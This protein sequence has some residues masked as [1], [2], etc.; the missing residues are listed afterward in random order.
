M[1]TIINGI[2]ILINS[3]N[4]LHN[5]Y[6][7]YI[8]LDKYIDSIDLELIKTRV[9]N[10]SVIEDKTALFKKFYSTDRKRILIITS[11]ILHKFKERYGIGNLL[12]LLRKM[13]V[14]CIDHD[15]TLSDRFLDFINNDGVVLTIPSF[16]YEIPISLRVGLNALDSESVSNI[17][18]FLSKFLLNAFEEVDLAVL[19]SIES[20][21]E[22]ID[23]VLSFK[24][25]ALNMIIENNSNYLMI[26]TGLVYRSIFSYLLEKN[27][28]SFFTLVK[29]GFFSRRILRELISFLEKKDYVLLLNEF[30]Y[31]KKMI[32]EHVLEFFYRGE[33][34]HIPIIISHKNLTLV[35][36]NEILALIE[37]LI[38]NIKHGLYPYR[39]ISDDLRLL[40]PIEP[41]L[42]TL[43]FLLNKISERNELIVMMPKLLSGIVE[44]SKKA[45]VI[46]FRKLIDMLP[47]IPS[48]KHNEASL[49]ILVLIDDISIEDINELRTLND[50][51]NLIFLIRL[52]RDI[53]TIKFLSK[54][55]RREVIKIDNPFNLSKAIDK[56]QS[57]SAIISIELKDHYKDE[58]ETIYIDQSKCIKCYNCMK[59]T[60]CPA[61]SS[62]INETLLI[63]ST[64][65]RRCGICSFT[66]KNNAII[67]IKKQGNRNAI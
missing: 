15:Y 24:G 67:I 6:D 61:I 45:S 51:I 36:D 9:R 8:F 30:N 38:K 5:K 27:K 21:E 1:K 33:I 49:N 53:D 65:C 55:L 12:A 43:I 57:R 34:E 28:L 19:G 56:I 7:I 20:K 63:D 40:Y 50:L 44:I 18:V 10:I 16:L 42:I 35:P 2:D 58:V 47:I 13:L 62:R 64:I 31:L 3:I 29:I 14:I 46:V 48:L 26:A 54:V 4:K 66:C 25:N 60:L 37:D 17:I 32:E 52:K 11:N 22:K 41:A 23:N 39:S 59:Y